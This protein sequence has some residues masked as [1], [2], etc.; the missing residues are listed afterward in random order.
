L[1]SDGYMIFSLNTSKSTSRLGNARLND[2]EK[3]SCFDVIA[4]D[5]RG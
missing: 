4:G 3:R 1:E 5:S 2:E